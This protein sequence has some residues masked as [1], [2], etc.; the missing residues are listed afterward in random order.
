VPFVF[1]K[2]NTHKVEGLFKWAG[3]NIPTVRQAPDILDCLAWA[4]ENREEYQRLFDF[5]DRANPWPGILE[6]AK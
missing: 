2:V 4:V 1:C 5:L 6:E 3:V